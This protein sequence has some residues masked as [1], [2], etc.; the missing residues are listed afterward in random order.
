[1]FFHIL[2][3]LI[4][5]AFSVMSNMEMMQNVIINDKSQ[6]D[7]DSGIFGFVSAEQVA[8]PAIDVGKKC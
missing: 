4:L 3:T 1:M 8:A 5:S 7:R 6:T 2:L